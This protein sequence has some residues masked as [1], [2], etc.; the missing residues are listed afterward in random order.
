MLTLL[1]SPT[2]SVT[3][4]HVL[5]LVLVHTPSM[6]VLR[7]AFLSHAVLAVLSA[8]L[9]VPPRLP[10][11]LF[12]LPPP[13]SALGPL[14]LPSFATSAIHQPLLASMMGLTTMMMPMHVRLLSMTHAKIPAAPAAT[15]NLLLGQSRLN[16]LTTVLRNFMTGRFGRAQPAT[17]AA[18]RHSYPIKLKPASSTT[19]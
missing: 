4:G 10:Q 16:N 15:M 8:T 6:I 1:P 3:P 17:V 19:L 7:V 18:R 5:T 11:T 9:L 13:S 2:S 12:L 14:C